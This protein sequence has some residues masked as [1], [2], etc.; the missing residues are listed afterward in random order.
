MIV[1]LT[2]PLVQLPLENIFW[3]FRDLDWL[4]ADY[5]QCTMFLDNPAPLIE[6]VTK[7]LK[8]FVIFSFIRIIS[9]HTQVNFGKVF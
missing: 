2:I 1:A 4:I 9:R 5:R 6:I 3:L 8:G 7:V